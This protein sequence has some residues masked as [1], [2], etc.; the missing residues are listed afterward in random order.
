MSSV[1]PLLKTL[2]EIELECADVLEQKQQEEKERAK[3]LD[4]FERKKKKI[5][6]KIRD[7]KKVCL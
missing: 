6:D 4:E 2:Y 3:N 1:T 7:I 5:A